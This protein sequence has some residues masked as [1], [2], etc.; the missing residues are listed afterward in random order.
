MEGGGCDESLNNAS[1]DKMTALADGPHVGY[2]R[3]LASFTDRGRDWRESR[4]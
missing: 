1:K 4:L 3:E 2:E